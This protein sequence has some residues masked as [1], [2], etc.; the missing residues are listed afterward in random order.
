M[1][2]LAPSSLFWPIVFS[3]YKSGKSFVF[4]TKCCGAPTN[5]NDKMIINII[6]TNSGIK[7]YSLVHFVK[8]T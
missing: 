8:G 6:I 7:Q 5:N 1:T 3:Y 2:I 4:Q